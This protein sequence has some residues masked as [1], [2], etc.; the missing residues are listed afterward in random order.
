MTTKSQDSE[1]RPDSSADNE[2]ADQER[3]ESDH[4]L[5][6]LLSVRERISPSLPSSLV[7][8]CY[9]VQREHQYTQDKQVPLSM[10]R[11]IIEQYVKR[12]LSESQGEDT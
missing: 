5:S 7:E 2:G 11:K 9:K 1:K 4:G 3:A 12:T 8:H 6:V 10:T